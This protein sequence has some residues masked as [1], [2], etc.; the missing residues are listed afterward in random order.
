MK[1][2]FIDID[3]VCIGL[4]LQ[5]QHA[6]HQCKVFIPVMRYDNIGRGLVSRVNDWRDWMDWADLIVMTG[7]G[8][9]MRELDTYFEKGY[10][11]L[12]ANWDSA[13]LEIDRETGMN[14]FERVGMDCLPYRS[15]DSLDEGMEHVRR[16]KGTFVS[17]PLHDNADKSTTYC[18]SGPDDMMFMMQKW[19]KQGKTYPFLLQEKIKACGEVGVSGWFGPHGWCSVWEEDFEHKPLMPGN[20]GPNTGEMGNVCKYVDDSKLARKFLE[21]LTDTLHALKFRG[22]FAMGLIC[23]TDGSIYPLECTARLGWPITFMQTYLHRQPMVEFWADLLAGKD[24]LRVR[25]DHC[26]GHVIGIKPFPYEKHADSDTCEGFPLFGVDQENFDH[27]QLAQ[28][29]AGKALVG[30]KLKEE[31]CFVTAGPYVACAV[32]SG[33]SITQAC[34]RSFARAKALRIPNSPMYRNDIGKGLGGVLEKLQA[35]GYCEEWVF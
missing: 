17:K 2:L 12:G 26:C 24:S 13:Q 1:V 7:N 5:A 6:G 9:Y 21:P 35:R 19:K 18:S 28:V 32:D 16:T 8:K 25:R 15:F 31:E 27:Y 23:A 11:I 14:C 30:E 34:D 33:K 10:P 20:I 3:G 29:R 22:N 4:A